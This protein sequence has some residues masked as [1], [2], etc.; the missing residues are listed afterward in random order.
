MHAG[1][2][3]PALV[4][5]PRHE[6]EPCPV[7]L[8]DREGDVGG[9]RV[10]REA[11]AGH[12]D[13]VGPGVARAPRSTRASN[14]P[15]GA[16]P[17]WIR[18]KHVRLVL[19]PAEQV[20]GDVVQSRAAW[21]DDEDLRSAP[22]G[23]ADPQVQDRNLLLGVEAREHDHLR[24]LDVPVA[25]SPARSR[26]SAPRRVHRGTSRRWSRSLVPKRRP[27]ELRQRVRVLV[28][29]PA[30]GEERDPAARAP[31]RRSGRTPR[32]TRPA[33][34]RGRGSAA[35]SRARAGRD[36]GR[37]S[38]PCRTIHASFTSRLSR[39]RIAH[40][41]ARGAGRPGRCTRRCSAGTR[42]RRWTGRTGGRRTGTASR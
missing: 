21:V 2:Q 34:A 32:R 38:A 36:A 3:R 7:P 27:R 23:L 19:G 28:E 31:T 4:R 12:D 14:E 26:P 20:L 25:S 5:A 33:R 17:S 9:E 18:S 6:G 30:T 8:G 24:A 42:S 1:A 15:S 16:S 39:A 29:Q 22:S 35:S 41:L 40:H 11:F 10:L 37:R 13:G